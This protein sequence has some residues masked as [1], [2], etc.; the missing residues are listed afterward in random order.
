[1]MALTSNFVP[2]V[3]PE[4]AKIAFVGQAPGAEED[5]LLEPFVGSAGM[6]VFNPCLK[7][8][9]I[10]RSE[11][12]I[13]NLFHKRPPRNEVGY[14]YHDKRCTKL[15]WEGQEHLEETRRWLEKL[16]RQRDAGMGG[17][18]ILVSLGREATLALT[19][20]DKISKWRGS[21]LP[22]T[23]VEGFK[24]Y[25][26][27]HPSYIL[28][29]MNEPEEKVQGQKKKMKMNALPLFLRDLQRIRIQSEFPDIRRA[30]RE[31]L[32][33]E[34][35]EH[36]VE[37][38]REC[39]QH[40]FVSCDIETIRTKRGPVVWCIGFAPTPDRALTIPI[41][42][43]GR[44]HLSSHEEK[45]LWTEIS[46][47]FLTKETL[48]IFQF[49]N[50]DLSI[51][52]RYYGLRLANGTYGDTMWCFQATYP[53]MLSGLATLTSWY[54]WEP[55]Y[56]DD[57]KW[58][59]GRRI[60]DEAEFLYNAKDC[61]VTREIWPQVM[62]DCRQNECLQTYRNHIRSFPSLLRMMIQGVGFDSKKQTELRQTWT[63]ECARLEG[64]VNEKLGFEVNIN[65]SQQIQ[66]VLYG[67]L[68]MKMMFNKKTGQPSVDKDALNRL[69]KKYPDEEVLDH[70]LNYK[71]LDKLISTYTSMEAD[72]DGRVRTSYGWISTFRLNSSE[73]HFGG[74]GN[75]Q[76]IPVRSEEGIEIRKLFI[77]DNGK[78]L[79]GSDLVQAEAMEVAWL[80]GDEE[81]IEAFLARIDVHWE[82]AKR[83]FRLDKNLEY[84]KKA[85]IH[86]SMLEDEVTMYLLRHI[87]K[88]A[89]H[90]GNYG[91]GPYKLQSILIMQGIELAFAVCK[92]LLD[93]AARAR[94]M[95]TLWQQRT[96]EEI[97]LT[98]VL[99]NCFGDR[100]EFR[101]RLSTSLF[102]SAYAFRPQSVVGRILQF[103][104]Q[105]IHENLEKY[106]PLLNVH[107]EVIGQCY[108]QDV[109]ENAK[110]IQNCLMIPH[111]PVKGKELIIPCDFK[112]GKSWG[113]MKE[114]GSLEELRKDY[115]P[116]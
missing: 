96:Q 110:Q 23:L 16:K 80:S 73:S 83:I 78:I 97:R 106:E 17:P 55:Y 6:F 65:S 26:A 41:I 15:T 7:S 25:P 44:Q 3:G 103:G 62:S 42:K 87:A 68:G 4:D 20:Q 81:L 88:T 29:L 70:I 31:L 45:I 8:A 76:N 77:P 51:L 69:K 104:I 67:F 108:P 43:R 72:D 74:G 63:A 64:L 86:I 48:K 33:A 105:A 19:G 56:K 34:N 109:Y 30:E 116:N 57:G 38:L 5:R 111:E 89:V 28:R 93:D 113:E 53:Y 1:M 71:K 91:M 100:R 40:E 2:P 92:Q 60:S 59:D 35:L 21:I 84:D 39:A 54:T 13:W 11:V 114:Y 49:G 14:F 95:R 98:R 115:P 18:N 66:K 47:L 12:L 37:F 90:A 75:L 32:I 61:A 107:D 99:Y 79:L 102:N 52:G 85:L 36:S 112:V 27:H 50:Y 94:P 9:G 22:C 82:N 101:G 58:W 46:R 10:L 24:V